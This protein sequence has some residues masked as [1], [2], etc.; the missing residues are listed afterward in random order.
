MAR[1]GKTEVRYKDFTF[2]WRGKR[3]LSWWYRV[4]RLALDRQTSVNEIILKSL[5]DKVGYDS[6]A[7]TYKE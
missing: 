3:P 6:E 1:P 2:R 5:D 7:E 4:K